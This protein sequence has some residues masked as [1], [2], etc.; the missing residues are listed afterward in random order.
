MTKAEQKRKE[1]K[2]KESVKKSGWKLVFVGLV[3]LLMPE[4]LYAQAT[5]THPAVT[6]PVLTAPFGTS[7]YYQFLAMEQLVK[8]I[9]PWLRVKTLE[10]PGSVYNVT[11]MAKNANIRKTSLVCLS[12]GS[13][14]LG[15]QGQVPYK[16][17]I[18]FTGWKPL[19]GMTM[20]TNYFV[21]LNPKIK[22]PQDLANARL[23]TGRAVQSHWCIY[24][25][26]F[27]EKGNDLKLGKV[28]KLGTMESVRAL[29]DRVVDA[30]AI[31]DYFTGDLQKRVAAA[32]M[33]ELES[34]GHPLY[35]IEICNDTAMKKIKGMGAPFLTVTIPTGKLINQKQPI[36]SFADI[37]CAYAHESFPEDIAYE[38]TKFVIKNIDKLCVQNN[39]WNLSNDATWVS[40]QSMKTLHPGAIRAYKEAGIK[41]PE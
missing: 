12:E 6:L 23:G 35:Y 16:E 25:L 33:K 8:E 14:W 30:I 32:P 5:S 38:V 40:G 22:T 21:S 39:F 11:E 2:M 15:E 31:A 17:S 9:H 20:L 1:K 28:D 13:R 3:L 18:K 19:F 37:E 7:D 26:L 10:T 27:L 41:I 4:G 34:S 24:P 36:M 29:L